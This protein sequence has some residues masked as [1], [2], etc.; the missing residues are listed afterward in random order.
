MNKNNQPSLA[1]SQ[2]MKLININK[3]L[4]SMQVGK[5]SSP[6][7]ITVTKLN[8]GWTK[9]HKL[10]PYWSYH[11]SSPQTIQQWHPKLFIYMDFVFVSFHLLLPSLVNVSFDNINFSFVAFSAFYRQRRCHLQFGTTSPIVKFGWKVYGVHYKEDKTCNFNP[12]KSLSGGTKEE[13]K[14]V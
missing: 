6:T 14:K 13:L 1:Q 7:C 5:N 9:Q 10:R 4:A 2:N 12:S 8:Y 3:Y 11:L